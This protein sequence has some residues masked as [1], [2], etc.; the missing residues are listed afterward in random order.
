MTCV[1]PGTATAPVW[2]GGQ[3]G[4][5]RGRLDAGRA[6]LI[7]SVPLVEGLP[8]SFIWQTDHVSVQTL[9]GLRLQGLAGILLTT[10]GVVGRHALSLAMG[11][12][13]PIAIGR[14]QPTG[15]VVTIRDGGLVV[16]WDISP[17]E[18]T[19]WVRPIT[20]AGPADAV[21][22]ITGQAEELALWG[23]APK[24][25]G[26]VRIEHLALLD[27]G[28]D[29]E[30]LELH[31]ARIFAAT[32]NTPVCVRLAN[33]TAD[34]PKPPA[35][36]LDAASQ[37]RAIQRAAA[38]RPNVRVAVRRDDAVPVGTGLQLVPFVETTND[39]RR[40]DPGP[41]WVGLGDLSTAAG[42]CDALHRQLSELGRRARGPL[43]LCGIAAPWR[44]A[45]TVTDAASRGR[46]GR[47][48]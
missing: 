4:S 30:D 20:T 6:A 29:S 7:G 26:L 8:P 23:R 37:I 13:V 21:E 44:D 19:V 40:L 41:V 22:L 24:E 33:W 39:A 1:L 5:R 35:F 12:G 46:S 17:P 25:V 2:T 10:R 18:N 48:P 14:P 9:L 31:L 3:P 16:P 43:Y 28:M 27:P 36:R 45:K 34:K 42:T 11:L 15:T 38:A 47:A 32:A